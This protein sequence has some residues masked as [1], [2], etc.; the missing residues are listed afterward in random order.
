MLPFASLTLQTV[1]NPL[2][3]PLK[4]LTGGPCPGEG[5]APCQ[6]MRTIGIMAPAMPFVPLT[7]TTVPNYCSRARTRIPKRSAQ[8]NQKGKRTEDRD[9][10]QLSIMVHLTGA[11][12]SPQ[13]SQ[14][15]PQDYISTVSIIVF[16]IYLRL[17]YGTRNRI[18]YRL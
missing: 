16:F 15:Y 11:T 18:A 12:P 4:P 8:P 10:P 1:G 17:L 3:S 5:F 13:L 9:C 14:S 7:L 6:T 2:K